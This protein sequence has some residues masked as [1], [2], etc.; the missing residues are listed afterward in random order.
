MKNFLK[1]TFVV[2]LC[3]RL[4]LFTLVAGA[5]DGSPFSQ[6]YADAAHTQ[7]EAMESL[8]DEIEALLDAGDESA[9]CEAIEAYENGFKRCER[10]RT[11]RGRVS[12]FF[13]QSRR[14][15]AVEEECGA[16]QGTFYNVTKFLCQ[17]LEKPD[18][19]GISPTSSSHKMEADMLRNMKR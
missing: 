19:C 6:D 12:C 11:L 10:A 3:A 18:D 7:A 1:L 13:A 4:V 5:S 14:T 8:I 15:L 16:S 2:G 9:C 17:D